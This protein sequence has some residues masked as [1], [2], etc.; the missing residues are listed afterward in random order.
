MEGIGLLKLL[1]GPIF[2]AVVVILGYLGVKF[3]FKK[4]KPKVDVKA[5]GEKDAEHIA[6]DAKIET[7][8]EAERDHINKELKNESKTN[9]R[10]RFFDSFKRSRPGR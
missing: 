3:L 5:E 1:G 10:R 7:K 9:V 2:G 6:E 8:A 4:R